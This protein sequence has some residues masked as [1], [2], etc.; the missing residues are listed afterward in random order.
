M[1]LATGAE[2]I[3]GDLP[4]SATAAVDVPLEAGDAEGTRIRRLSTI[5][6]VRERLTAALAEVE[7]ERGGTPIV[8]G[9]DCGVAYAPVE[10]AAQ[11][12]RVALLWLDAHP[13][14]ESAESSPSGAYTGMVL[15]HLVDDGVLHGSSI[16][17]AGVRDASAAEESFLA[18]AGVRVQDDPAGIAEALL[19]TNADA[20]HLH[21]DLDVLDPGA[22]DAAHSTVPFGWSVEQLLT[23]VREARSA[24]PLVGASIAGFAPDDAP[25]ADMSGDLA[26]ILRLIGALAKPA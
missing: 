15:R 14:A 18:E 26:T 10:H 8:I 1:R 3:R 4:A 13:D 2:A 11:T 16:V 25:G 21:V 6:L 20:L 7:N 23:T 12:R 5:R 9:G 24:L 22:F 19:A 17:L